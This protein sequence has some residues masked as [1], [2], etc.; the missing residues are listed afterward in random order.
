MIKSHLLGAVRAWPLLAYF[1]LLGWSPAHAALVF[2]V[3][4][5]NDTTA[6]ITA[7]GSLDIAGIGSGDSGGIANYW[8][9]LDGAT[10]TGDPGFDSFIGAFTIGGATPDEV[11]TR[12]LTNDFW[13]TFA[14]S[15]TVGSTITGLMTA[16]L[17]VETWAAAGATGTISAGSNIVGSYSV[18]SA[19]PIPAAVWLFG[20]GLLGLAGIA[21][22]KKAA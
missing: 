14:A 15:P 22:R 17:D 19:V 6:Q 9:S 11:F 7:T 8:L 3:L 10:S 20:S 21:R 12:K 16:T 18:I 2:E 4:R 1:A 13:L 5:I